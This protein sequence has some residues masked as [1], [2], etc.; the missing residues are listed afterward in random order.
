MRRTVVVTGGGKGI[1]RAIAERFAGLGD[2]VIAL[3]RDENAL[4]QLSVRTAVCDVTDER[5]VADV[6][7]GLP[8]VDVL[9]N[10]AGVAESAPLDRTTLE[11]WGRHFDV[12]VTGPLLCMRAVVPGMRERRRGSII[13]IASTAARSGRSLHMRLHRIQARSRRPDASSCERAGRDRGASQCGLP[14]VRA[15]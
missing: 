15:N 13:T 11:S 7:G 3:G 14:H 6:I 9:V 1:G 4:A 10:N 12:N 2:E 8:S 5:A